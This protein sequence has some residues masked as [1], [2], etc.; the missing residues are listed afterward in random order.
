MG[1]PDRNRDNARRAR[2]RKQTSN[3]REEIGAPSNP[4][5]WG[6]ANPVL[7]TDVPRFRP[8]R[9]LFQNLDDLFFGKS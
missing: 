3:I 1:L 5:V 2:R 8:E 4:Q 6:I 9:A 7:A